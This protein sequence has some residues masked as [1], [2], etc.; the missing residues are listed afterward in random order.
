MRIQLLKPYD[1]CNCKFYMCSFTFLCVCLCARKCVCVCMFKLSL[2]CPTREPEALSSPSQGWDCK[3]ISPGRLFMWLVWMNYRSCK[4]STVIPALIHFPC[5]LSLGN[6]LFP[7]FTLILK[8]S[9]A[10]TQRKALY[11]I[12]TKKWCK[13][14]GAD[15]ILSAYSKLVINLKHINFICRWILMHSCTKTCM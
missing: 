13:Y 7:I 1:I 2:V 3:H 12:A 11:I 5:H 8:V 4:L 15:K 9:G 6:V 14:L 10:K